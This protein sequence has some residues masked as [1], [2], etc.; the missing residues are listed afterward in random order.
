MRAA[1]LVDASRHRAIATMRR[2]PDHRPAKEVARRHFFVGRPNEMWVADITFVPTLAGFLFMAVFMEA[3]S[4]RIAVW[5]F[6]SDLKT[7]VV[8]AAFN[9]A[10]A[11]RK[12]E[13]IIHLSNQGA[14]CTPLVFGNRCKDAGVTPSTVSV[15]DA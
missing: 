7:R 11:V 13:R 2:D 3:W 1:G 10:L 4:R 14:Q 12:P 8:L 15:G 6:S 9:M 5:A